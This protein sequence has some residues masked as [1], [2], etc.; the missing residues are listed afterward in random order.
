M[1]IDGLEQFEIA[2]ISTTRTVGGGDT[3]FATVSSRSLTITAGAC[4][5]FIFIERETRRTGLVLGK[6]WP[7]FASV[8]RPGTAARRRS[9]RTV[10][11]KKL[12]EKALFT[13]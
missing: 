7:S 5:T 8:E 9:I 3:V 12:G 13:T 2:P 6:Y 4:D 10:L 11:A 1:P